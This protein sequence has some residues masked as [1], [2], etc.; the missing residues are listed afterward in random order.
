MT[1][2]Q[3]EDP[4]VARLR[5]IA[6]WVLVAAFAFASLQVLTLLKLQAAGADFSCF[7][8]GAKTALQAPGR[9]Y[10]F[11][12]VTQLQGWPL[13]PEKLRPYIYP[14]SALLFFIP[15]TLAPYWIDYALWTGVSAVIFLWAGLRAR[16]PWWMMLL[17]PVAFEI[18]CGQVTLLVGGL[19]VA[20]LS[21]QKTR[22]IVAGVLYGL[23]AAVKPQIA[24]LLPLALIADR[25][26]RGLVAASVT[27]CALALVSAA[28]CGVGVWW[29][30]I[31]ALGR[32]QQVIFNDPSLVEDTVTPY[33]ALQS[34]GANGAWA[35]LIAPAVLFW[36]WRT[37]RRTDDLA[38]RSIAIFAGALFLSPYAMNYE[39]ALLAP[40]VAIYLART[41]DPRWH[42]YALAAVLYVAMPFVGVAKIVAVAC[43][44]VLRLWRPASARPA[45]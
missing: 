34:V 10:D 7:W 26:W 28:I 42:G 35:F 20:G 27:G 43:L 15:F 11:G 32:F 38:D 19:I 2:Q 8:A 40:A 1:T 5:R 13:G 45:L 16:A 18:Y 25:R 24:V 3:S 4:E 37:F 29:D 31:L 6:L 17:P 12:Y 21:Y 41:K 9:L 36:V 22:P 44:P 30:W 39:A 23:A 14:P 33:G